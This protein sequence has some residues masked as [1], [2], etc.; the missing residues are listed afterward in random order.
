MSFQSRVHKWLLACFGAE[1]AAHKLERSHRFFEE[2]V[3]LVQALDMPRD[4]AHMLVEYVYNRPLGEPRQ[5]VG[6]VKLTLAAL[7]SANGLDEVEDGETE[8]A[9]VWTKVEQIRAKQ[10][11]KPKHSPLP[12]HVDD[13]KDEEIRKLRVL[14]ACSY[15]SRSSLLYTDGELQDN[16]MFPFIDFKRDTPEEVQ[17]KMLKRAGL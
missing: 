10:A 3:E 8:L 15:C 5:E 16:R 17:A 9:R 13:P 11:T 7:C 2:A 12:M 1:I 6:G 14:L 4:H